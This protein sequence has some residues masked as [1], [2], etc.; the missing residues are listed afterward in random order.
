MTDSRVFVGRGREMSGL[1]SALGGDTRLLLVVGDAGVGKTRFV[2][3]GLRL[4]AAEPL[5]SAWGAC[6]P[7][8]EQLPFLPV[9]EALDALS[10][11]EGGTLLESAL[12]SVPQ[13]ARV[14]AGRLLPQLQSAD[15]GGG[16]SGWWRRARMF[17]GVAELLAALARG[18][19]LVI[20]IEDV[21]WADS[22]TLDFLTFLARGGRG[23][24]VT[25]VA[26]CRSDEVPLEPHVT[27]WLAH[28]R[29]GGQVEEIRLAPLSREEVAEQVTA[30]MGDTASAK[31]VLYRAAGRRCARRAGRRRA[32]PGRRAA[33]PAGRATGRAGQRLWRRCPGGAGGAGGRWPAADRGS[34]VPSGRAR[35]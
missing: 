25:V 2:T 17:S 3:E 21:H 26:T 30:L 33:D 35:R 24:A 20:V 18:A 5:L 7:L 15:A 16:P 14:E 6:L 9:A 32:R 1:R 12:A 11:L 34:A 22:A 10:R 13:Y 23:E 31:P 4:A 19:R 27:R 28:V 29:A 8:A